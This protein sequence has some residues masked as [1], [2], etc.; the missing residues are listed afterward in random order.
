MSA[1]R[2]PIVRLNDVND[3]HLFDDSISLMIGAAMSAA[4]TYAYLRVLCGDTLCGDT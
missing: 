3:V 2:S 4:M 1:N